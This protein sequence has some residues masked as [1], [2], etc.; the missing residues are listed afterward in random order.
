M[1][2]LLSVDRQ[3]SLTKLQEVVLERA[4]IQSGR[5]L[6]FAYLRN[7]GTRFVL[8]NE[9]DFKDAFLSCRQ[10]EELS[11]QSFYV[12]GDDDSPRVME[13]E[14]SENSIVAAEDDGRNIVSEALL[15]EERISKVEKVVEKQTDLLL[16]M[17]TQIRSL[18]EESSKRHEELSALLDEID[19]RSSNDTG[20]IQQFKKE[21]A[22][23]MDAEAI[24]MERITDRVEK[25]EVLT[26][27][28]LPK[29]EAVALGAVKATQELSQR[30]KSTPSPKLE[31]VGKD[32]LVALESKVASMQSTIG[33]LTEDRNEMSAE[34]EAAAKEL[35]D[36]LR[37]LE[38]HVRRQKKQSSIY[39]PTNNGISGV[40]AHQNDTKQK[41]ILQRLSSLEEA[42]EILHDSVRPDAEQGETVDSAKISD[43]DADQVP[44]DIVIDARDES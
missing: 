41:E 38:A 44:R 35:G 28:A 12:G 32:R 36:R 30:V 3:P 15:Q 19:E 13:G 1:E 33:T 40:T 34:E 39:M 16:A 27:D 31:F 18:K 37:R 2:R 26:G 4:E 42:M 24:A 10:T 14:T 29:L 7:D 21:V 5:P 20:G 6:A 9:M 22:E 11:I 8:A 23:S 17:Q 43:P 25:L